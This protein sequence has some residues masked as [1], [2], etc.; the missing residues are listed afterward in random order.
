MLGLIRMIGPVA[1][2][3]LGVS[4]GGAL[5]WA[6]FWAWNNFV[7]NPR[8]VAVTK[9]TA[10]LE[11]RIRVQEAADAAEKAERDRQEKASEAAIRAFLEA[12][13]E[14]QRAQE[15]LQ[16]QLEQEISDYEKQLA[17]EGRQCLT[18]GADV[19]WLR[20]RNAP[21]R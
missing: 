3:V 5:S 4:G 21:R 11:C 2:L 8:L 1:A 6:G 15:A 17:A 7:D 19:E 13:D 16:E 12:A 9:A 14:R 18:D 20:G 10:E